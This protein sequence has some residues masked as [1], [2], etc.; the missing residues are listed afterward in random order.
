MARHR[1][2]STRCRVHKYGMPAAFAMQLTAV[3][4]RWS[5]SSCRFTISVRRLRLKAASVRRGQLPGRLRSGWEPEA[6]CLPPS[7]LAPCLQAHSQSSIERRQDQTLGWQPPGNPKPPPRPSGHP[8]S[9][10]NRRRDSGARLKDTET[11]A[12]PPIWVPK[13]KAGLTPAAFSPRSPRH[14]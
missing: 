12:A 11:Q 13:P 14:P 2:F 3:D 1:S 7:A 5:T 9:E 8:P 10:G 6:A 4:S